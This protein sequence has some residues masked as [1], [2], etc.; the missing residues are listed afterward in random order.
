MARGIF[1][2]AVVASCTR[3]PCPA[4][5]LPA[6]VCVAAGLSTDATPV[7]GPVGLA[8]LPLEHLAARIAG[9]LGHEVDRPWHLEPS[10][11]LAAEA[12][13]LVRRG[14]RAGARD[15]ERLDGL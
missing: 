11:L 4:A 14:G 13:D 7:A 3:G 6:L 15:H 9:Q 2:M 8:Q 12:D 5:A 1:A 10:Q